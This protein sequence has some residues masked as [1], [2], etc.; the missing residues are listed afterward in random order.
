MVQKS[1]VSAVP[2]VRDESFKTF[3]SL[4]STRKISLLGFWFQSVYVLMILGC[5]LIKGLLFISRQSMLSGDS[6]FFRMTVF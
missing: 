5:S 4:S 6:S 1:A 3:W 2:D